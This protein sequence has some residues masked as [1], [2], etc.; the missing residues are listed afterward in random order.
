MPKIQRHL[1]F[2]LRLTAAEKELATQKAQETGLS[3]SELF[4]T[5]TLKRNLPQKVTEI[6]AQTYWELGKIGVNLNQITYAINTAI[7]L[8]QSLPNSLQKL[9]P[10][11][12]QLE[13][14]L[15]QIR[16]E[17]TDTPE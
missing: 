1:K 9:T 13:K 4:R 6:S 11:L 2:Q 7:K 17:I 15:H 16:R 3:L 14:L 10:E 8:G 12:Q 5:A